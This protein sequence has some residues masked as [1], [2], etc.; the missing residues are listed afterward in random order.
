MTSPFIPQEQQ[1]PS[2]SAPW[3]AQ[4]AAI[5]TAVPPSQYG[6]NSEAL[7]LSSSFNHPDAATAARRFAGE[8]EAFIYSRFSNPTVA[9][10]E[11]RLAAMEG[12]EAAIATA[13]GMGALTLLCLSVLQAGDHIVCSRSVFGS[14][15]KLLGS[16]IARFGVETTFVSQTDVAEW[17]AAIRPGKTKMLLAE[18]PTNPLTEVCDIAALA[19]VAHNAGALLVV[20]NC[21]C[22]PALQKPLALGA[23]VVMQSATKYLDGQ[24]RVIAGALCASN[25]LIHKKILPVQRSMGITLS[26][27]NAWVVLKG[28]ETL[29]LR[30]KAHSEQALELAQWLESHPAVDRVFYP[31]LASHP[32]HTLAM[33]QQNAMGKGLG[34]A[35]LSFA[36]KGS[37]PEELRANAFAV[38]DQTKFLSITANLGDVKT[39][40]TH[41]AS[42]T[43]GRLSEEQR[44]AAGIHQ[45]VLRVAVGLEAMSDIQ[46]DL[47]TGLNALA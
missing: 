19:D 28:L 35:V 21:F 25:E 29:N 26:P 36:V 13:S 12:A 22:T 42:T 31:G 33:R 8:E 18:T 38:I 2:T 6:E 41:P 43:H 39:I 7:Y 16:E 20:D 10:M 45:G 34:G 27:F 14:I 37:T 30:M 46:R 9:S 11:L 44:L 1:K 32:Q 15:I 4:T 47:A 40:I 3:Q 17:K 24:G 23:D 5:R